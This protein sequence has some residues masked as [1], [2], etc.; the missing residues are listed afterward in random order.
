MQGRFV[1]SG[2]LSDSRVVERLNADFVPVIVNP[3]DAE[4]SASRRASACGRRSAIR[5]MA[6]LALA[7]IRVATDESIAALVTALDDDV[8][9]VRRRA[10]RA[11]GLLDERAAPAV[12]ALAEAL[13]SDPGVVNE[14]GWAL[15]RIG[16]PA[17]PTIAEQLAEDLAE[18]AMLAARRAML[19]ASF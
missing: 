7:R 10:A 1:K 8:L 12:P 5:D 11:L 17:I 19:A 14:A 15:G 16:A 13:R 4:A 9:Q 6:A 3:S 2:P 18:P